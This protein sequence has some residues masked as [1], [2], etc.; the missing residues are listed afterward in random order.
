MAEEEKIKLTQQGFQDLQ[1]ELSER[2]TTK[3]AEI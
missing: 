1:D 2:K 3:K